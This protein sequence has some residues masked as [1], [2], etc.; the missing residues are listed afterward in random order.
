MLLSGLIGLVKISVY[1][2]LLTP[3]EFGYYS[4]S[5]LLSTYGMYICSCGLYEGSM[6]LFPRW[7]GEGR[8]KDVESSR[9]KIAGFTVISSLA[10]SICIG[11]LL[12]SNILPDMSTGIAILMAGLF[13][14]VSTLFLLLLADIRSRLMTFEFGIIMFLRSILSIFLGTLLARKYGY[15]GILGSEIFIT[16]FITA[17]IARH[18]IHNFSWNFSEF[19]ALKPIFRVGL[20]LM[21]NGFVTSAAS[22]IDRFFVISKWGS[23]IFG[24]YSFAMI[25]A[26]GASLIQSILYQQISPE[27][28]YRIGRGDSPNKLLA[29]LNRFIIIIFVFLV[30][31]GYPFAV[32]IKWL[33]YNYF[34]EYLPAYSMIPIIYVGAS[35][36]IVSHYEYF[37]VAVGKTEY[38]LVLNIFV[39]TVV[40]LL[41]VL[42]SFLELSLISFASIYVIGRILYFISTFLL[43]RWAVNKLCA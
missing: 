27:I 18:T 13:A 35:V 33:I 20:P 37:I 43:S 1:A 25:L 26:T 10:L 9:N 21:L 39:V 12:A 17:I 23:T 15:V 11:I 29:N 32:M 6:G 31:F 16:G 7:Y 14:G 3:I 19:L 2:K 28:L 8:S 30:L 22:N 42:C 4:L 38:L 24:Y 34:P 36:I 41:S 40:L 5:L